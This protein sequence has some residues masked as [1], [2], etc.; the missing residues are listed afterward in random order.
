MALKLHVNICRARVIVACRPWQLWHAIKGLTVGLCSTGWKTPILKRSRKA[1]PPATKASN[2]AGGGGLVYYCSC[3]YVSTLWGEER[4]H[5]HVYRERSCK[6]GYLYVNWDL[7]FLYRIR[8]CSFSP[9]KMANIMV[10][11]ISVMENHLLFYHSNGPIITYFIYWRTWQ[12]L[13]SFA[14]SVLS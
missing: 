6:F 9:E 10:S 2:P 4:P 11:L 8:T 13:Y 7:K 14:K 12:D 3:N 1:V 5:L